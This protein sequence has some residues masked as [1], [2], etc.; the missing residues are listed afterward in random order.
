MYFF[1]CYWSLTTI[2]LQDKAPPT[3][4]LDWDELTPEQQKAAQVLGFNQKEWDAS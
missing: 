2:H 4:D 1:I 3:D